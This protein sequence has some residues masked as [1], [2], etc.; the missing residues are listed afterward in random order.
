MGKA[1]EFVA[2][3]GPLTCNGRCLEGIPWGEGG[4]VSGPSMLQ[5]CNKSN[6]LR[7]KDRVWVTV[8]LLFHRAAERGHSRQAF[9]LLT[10]PLLYIT[11]R[12]INT[13]KEAM[14]VP[15]SQAKQ[16][17]YSHDSMI[18]TRYNQELNADLSG[19]KQKRQPLCVTDDMCTGVCWGA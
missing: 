17:A 2:Y 13:H 19:K 7:T 11:K 5:G 15:G 9:R 12:W 8:C 14:T 10:H 18:G 4:C 16:W 1:E 6:G 3:A